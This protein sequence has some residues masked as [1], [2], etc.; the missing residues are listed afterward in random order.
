LYIILDEELIL[1]CIAVQEG[2]LE[3]LTKRREE[4]VQLK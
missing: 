3:F 2:K 1:R 4:R